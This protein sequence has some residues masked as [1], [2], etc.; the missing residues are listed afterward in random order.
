M[1]SKQVLDI[2]LAEILGKEGLNI[3]TPSPLVQWFSNINLHLNHLV[4]TGSINL[5]C[6]VSTLNF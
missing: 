6:W 4:R 1:I 5:D 2:S 3:G